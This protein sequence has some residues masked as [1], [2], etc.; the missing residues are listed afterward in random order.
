M[1]DVLIITSAPD[2][3][4]ILEQQSQEFL[5]LAVPTVSSVNGKIGAVVLRTGD[6]AEDTDRRYVTDA[7]FS[8][9]QSGYVPVSRTING[10]ALSADVVVTK[11]DIGLSAVDNIQQ[12]PLSYLDTDG[13]LAANSDTKVPSQKAV[14]TYVSGIIAAADAMV[15][16]GAI[17]ASSNPNYPAADAGWT[18]KISVA[19]KIGGASGPNVEAGDMIICTLDGSTAGNHATV[20]GNWNIIQVNIDG[21][22]V[23]PASA[24]D[25]AITVWDGTTGKLV[26]NS[27]VTIVSGVI[28]AARLLIGSGASPTY[29]VHNRMPTT[30]TKGYLLESADVTHG[31]TATFET[32]NTIMQMTRYGSAGGTWMRGASSSASVPGFTFDGTVGNN[33]PSVGGMS[34]VASKKNGGGTGLTKFAASET[35][36][37]FGHG[38]AG[39]ETN[40]LTLFGSGTARVNGNIIGGQAL[41]FG[42][43]LTNTALGFAIG[44]NFADGAMF[45]S[46]RYGYQFTRP[47]NVDR[48]DLEVYDGGGTLITSRAHTIDNFGNSVFGINSTNG[49][50]SVGQHTTGIGTV[51]NSAG[52][53]AVTG[54]GTQFLNTF[55]VGDTVT[56]GGQ[57]VAITAVNNNT[58]MTTATI[59]NANS[60][61]SYTLTGGVRFCVMGNGNIGIGSGATNPQAQLHIVRTDT[62]GADLLSP[63]ILADNPA[64]TSGGSAVFRARSGTGYTTYPEIW[65]EAQTGATG[66]VRL[67][68]VS[69]HDLQIR[70]NDTTRL[71]ILKTG[72][73]TFA[74]TC[75]SAGFIS[76]QLSP[77][78]TGITLKIRGGAGATAFSG[79]SIDPSASSTITSGIH[80]TME[81]TGNSI[82]APT[83]GTG[84]FNAFLISSEINQSGGAN[85]ISRGIYI[86]PTLTAAADFRALEIARGKTILAAATTAGTSLNIPS[87]TAPT[88]PNNGDIWFDG[89]DFKVRVGGVTKAIVLL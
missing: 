24:T 50:L 34:F 80:T 19:G 36:M 10:H 2:N 67:R 28:T 30:I 46:G 20:G 29:Q 12:L 66:V 45:D 3:T 77:A 51:S 88:S 81:I 79:L 86:N 76:N 48:L 73:A 82:F 89:T 78:N 27:A 23:G 53:G 8:G 72:E 43:N 41:S 11:S 4:L 42:Y 15:Y 26:K 38:A 85:G 47:S 61:V 18:Y 70:T 56:I 74:S 54:V 84:V 65:M 68:G 6:I 75:Q 13:T 64:T 52:S 31:M 83:S 17:N 39:A 63:Q 37:T 60:N 71:T 57:T 21:A 14:R 55:K 25:N 1:S 40:I 32:T 59:T 7:M 5:A 22:V 49:I 69:N 58:S 16:K 62:T 44:R 35:V 87:G 33:A 9:L